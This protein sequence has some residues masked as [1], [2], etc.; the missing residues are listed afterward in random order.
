[1]APPLSGPARKRM[2][3]NQHKSSAEVNPSLLGF[4]L[5]FYAD[6]GMPDVMTKQEPGATFVLVT[7]DD[8]HRPPIWQQVIEQ[9]HGTP[10]QII[11]YAASGVLSRRL[12]G[13]NIDAY[14]QRGDKFHLPKP[15]YNI[16]CSGE[17]SL[18]FEKPVLGTDALI[19]RHRAQSQKLVRKPAYEPA[20]SLQRTMK[21]FLSNMTLRAWRPNRPSRRLAGSH[22]MT[23]TRSYWTLP[24]SRSPKEPLE[25]KA[26]IF[27]TFSSALWPSM[28]RSEE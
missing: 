9:H 11:R 17:L 25:R 13:L 23:R 16:Y 2:D 27:S 1:M 22:P 10:C 5:C 8:L 7:D 21:P 12:R 24:P 15:L 18:V 19:D 28:K 14:N 20:A 3:P 6:D 4:C 26:T